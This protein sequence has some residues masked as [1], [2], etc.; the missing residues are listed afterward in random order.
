MPT[1]NGLVHIECGIKW[2][3]LAS[4]MEVEMG[5]GHFNNCQKGAQLPTTLIKIDHSAIP[6]HP[7]LSPLITLPLRVFSMIPPN[8]RNTLMLLSA[9]MCFY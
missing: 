9:G 8:S 1:A 6:I 3:V 7:S 2:N 4:T 5:G